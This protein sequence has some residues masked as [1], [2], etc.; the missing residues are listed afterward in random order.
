MFERSRK[1]LYKKGITVKV[2]KNVIKESDGVGW[3]VE[4]SPRYPPNIVKPKIF[5]IT[6]FRHCSATQSF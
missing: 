1:I 4:I 6:T 2:M 5:T 3:E